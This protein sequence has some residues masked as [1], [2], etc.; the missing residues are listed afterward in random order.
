[1]ASK[2]SGKTR[3][4]TMADVAKEAGVSRQLVSLVVRNTGYVAPEKR[5]LVVEAMQR[6][7]YQ[8]N[9]LAANLAAK[10]TNT[11][12]LAI[13]D[14]HNQVYAEFADGILEVIEPAGYKLLVSVTRKESAA[15]RTT[16]ESLVGLRVDGILVA[17]HFGADGRN[18]SQ[19][20]A[21]TPAVTLGEVA[22]EP[23]IGAISGNDS[24]G[25]KLAT[26]HLIKQGHQQIAYIA[27]PITHQN[28][29]RHRGYLSALED[30]GLA[31]LV[32]SGD[33]SEAG[34]KTAFDLA[35]TTTPRPTAF[36]CYNDATAFGVLSCARERGLRVPEDLAVVGYDNTTPAGYPGVDLTSVDQRAHEMGQLAAQALLERIR[37]QDAPL[38]QQS[39]APEL[40]I[41]RSSVTP[42]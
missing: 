18:L 37:D 38:E 22:D 12:G 25:G 13:F 39:L 3:S 16:V 4:V 36:F 29:D 11:I 17:T 34:G 1:M 26:E 15:D 9:T 8:R 5:E 14:L 28:A 42:N 24:L 19:A 31:E 27:A 10:Q 2:N 6:L 30:H 7:G 20:L 33:A 40:V 32:F 35:M 23:N 41:R 21:N